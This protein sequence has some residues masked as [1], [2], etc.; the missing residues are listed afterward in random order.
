MSK[1]RK[2][3]ETSFWPGYVDALVNVVLNI[4]FL[5]GLL[6]V[7]LVSLNFDSLGK[8]KEL[9]LALALESIRND[10]LLLASL[11][12]VESAV[13]ALL[14]EARKREEELQA[15]KVSEP[16]PAPSIAR[17]DRQK[18]VQIGRVANAQTRLRETELLQADGALPARFWTI[19]QE[20]KLPTPGELAEIRAGLQDPRGRVV[21]FAPYPQDPP[22]YKEA[23]FLGMQRLQLRLVQEGVAAS[24]IRLLMKPAPA[25]Q[26]VPG[27]LIFVWM[28]NSSPS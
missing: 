21:L 3:E 25:E 10:T 14:P 16:P 27:D 19:H 5:V 20:K 13:Q 11:G 2:I 17:V 7:G 8:N 12:T 1:K 28:E 18:V 22:Q 9:R 4:L 15:K 23:V 24:R 6:A 26:H